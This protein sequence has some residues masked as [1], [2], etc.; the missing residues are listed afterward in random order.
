MKKPFIRP[1]MI[2][3]A[4]DH[5]ELDISRAKRLLGWEPKRSLEETLP[6]MI[7]NLQQNPDAWYKMNQLEQK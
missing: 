5:Y 3:F 1:W 6:I 4:D 2:D 7:Q